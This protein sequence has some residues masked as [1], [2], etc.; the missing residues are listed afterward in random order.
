MNQSHA[1]KLLIKACKIGFAGSL[2]LSFANALNAPHRSKR[3][4]GV[5]K[6]PVLFAT[7]IGAGVAVFQ[8]IAGFINCKSKMRGSFVSSSIT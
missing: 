6:L 2:V 7:M 4:A 5:H 1:K 8:R 3:S